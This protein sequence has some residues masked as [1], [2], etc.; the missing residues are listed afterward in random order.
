MDRVLTSLILLGLLG[1]PD[2]DPRLA[3]EEKRISVK[4]IL[5]FSSLW[6]QERT[7]GRHGFDPRKLRALQ[8]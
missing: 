1:Y 2:F 5:F 3:L 4:D 7:R 8:E 6:T